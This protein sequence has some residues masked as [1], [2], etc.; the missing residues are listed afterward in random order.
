MGHKELDTI[1]QVTNYLFESNFSPFYQIN[2]RSELHH[3]IPLPQ[4]LIV[5]MFRCLNIGFFLCWNVLVLSLLKNIHLSLLLPDTSPFC[6]LPFPVFLPQCSWNIFDFVRL[7][8]RE[9]KD[10][11]HPQLSVRHAVGP[12]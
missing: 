4:T 12:Q 10:L 1:E 7:Y 9:G 11:L 5:F 6:D 2:S 8:T 3:T